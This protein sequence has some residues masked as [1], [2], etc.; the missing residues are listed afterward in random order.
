MNTDTKLQ[1]E[2][3]WDQFKGW[4]K[5]TWGDLTDD[6]FDQAEGN[7][8]K[9]VGVVKEKTGE[10]VDAIKDKVNEFMSR[11]DEDNDGGI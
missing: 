4:A 9:F 7:F 2:G 3:H 5:E 1:V 11:F 10:T 6:E 8:D